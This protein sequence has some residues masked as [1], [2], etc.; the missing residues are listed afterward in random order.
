MYFVH[1]LRHHGRH[2]EQKEEK[3][4]ISFKNVFVLCIQADHWRKSLV[5]R[6][7]QGGQGGARKEAKEEARTSIAGPRKR[8]QETISD[9]DRKTRVHRELGARPTRQVVWLPQAASQDKTTVSLDDVRYRLAGRA[10]KFTAAPDGHPLPPLPS[11]SGF[12]SPGTTPYQNGGGSDDAAWAARERGLICNTGS[13]VAEVLRAA[14]SIARQKT[15][16]R[17]MTMSLRQVDSGTR[18]V[19]GWRT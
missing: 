16:S 19:H 15:E 3:K 8:K 11:A 9:I 6:K 7:G 17:G 12:S 5:R 2:E 13:R 18:K 14:V 1:K 10:S 4:K